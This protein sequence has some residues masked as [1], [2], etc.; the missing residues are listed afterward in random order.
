MSGMQNNELVETKRHLVLRKLSKESEGLGRK[1]AGAFAE[2]S[3]SGALGSENH[4]SG[5]GRGPG[6]ATSQT[7][8]KFGL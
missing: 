4:G 3:W 1:C 5:K 2:R 7:I 8:V 6:E